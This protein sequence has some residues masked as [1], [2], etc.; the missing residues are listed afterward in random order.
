M[1]LLFSLSNKLRNMQE[2]AVEKRIQIFLTILALSLNL[3]FTVQAQ[4]N[5]ERDYYQSSGTKKMAELL[6]KI[7]AEQ[8]FKINPNK[9]LERANYY[10]EGLKQNLDIR[11]ELK[12]RV[13][14]A[15]EL[16]RSGESK[17]AAEELEK[18][19]L[20]I[21]EKGIIPAPFFIK[22]IRELL[23]I[24]YLR[25][26]EQENCLLNHN[27]ESCIFPIRAAGIHKLRDGSMAAITQLSLI[28]KDNP[29]DL[30]AKSLLNV[31]N[32]TLGSYPDKVPL[33]FLIPAKMFDSEYDLKRFTDVA[34]SVGLDVTNHAGGVVLD[35]LDGD[36]LF[37]VMISGQNPLDQLRFFHNNGDGSFAERTKEAGLTGE[38][39]GL[40]IIHADFD[41]T[42][43]QILSFCVAVGGRKTANIRFGF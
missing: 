11:N 10:R 14:L 35:D 43:F 9:S 22:Q 21:K 26:G 28:L 38:I 19:L 1:K 36:G 17:P 24:S 3:S 2:I 6:Q 41:K 4:M 27:H 34:P 42:D 40:N 15:D 5:A 12:V 16:L 7:Y 18:L 30:R 37:D 13:G 32:M 23:A 25:S 20:I 29:K 8:D 33:E 39:G 31:A